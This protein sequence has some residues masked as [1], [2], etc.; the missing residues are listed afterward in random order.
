MSSFF[1][2]SIGL[3]GDDPVSPEAAIVIIERRSNLT[4]TLAHLVVHDYLGT[5]R[6]KLAKSMGVLP[7][8][9]KSYWKRVYKKL[10]VKMDA[11]ARASVRDWVEAILRAELESGDDRQAA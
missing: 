8:T 10:D 4:P 9:L 3:A 7:E 5:S 6:E 1:A 11:Q 2:R